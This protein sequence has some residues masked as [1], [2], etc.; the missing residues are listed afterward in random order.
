MLTPRKAWAD[1]SR[2]DA[3][4]ARLAGLFRD[5]FQTYETAVSP[6]IRAAGPA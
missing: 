3:A 6:E 4:A 2:Y 1:A 5:N